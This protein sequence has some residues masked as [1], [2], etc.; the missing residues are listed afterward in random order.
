MKQRAAKILALLLALLMMLS[1]LAGCASVGP[2]GPQGATGQDGA[3]GETGMSAYE[4]AVERGYTGTVEEWIAS[5]SGAD[6]KSAYQLAVEKGYTGT[7]D[8]WLSSL[9][10]ENGRSAY[11]IAVQNGFVGSESAWLASLVGAQGPKGDKGDK[12][13]TGEQGAPGAAGIGVSDA[14]INNAYHLILVMTDGSEID[15]GYVGV[16][17]GPTGTSRAQWVA[18]L[19]DEAAYELVELPTTPTFTDISGHEYE[20]QIETAAY[21]ALID[22]TA[23]TFMPDELITREFATASAIKAMGYIP[24]D[25]IECDDVADIAEPEY[26]QLALELELV[27]LKDGSFCPVDVLMASEEA[28]IIEVL[29]ETLNSIS[30]PTGEEEGFVYNEGVVSLSSPAPTP[31]LNDLSDGVPEEPNSLV[32]YAEDGRL[33]LPLMPATQNLQPDQIITIDDQYAFKVVNATVE[34][35]FVLVEFVDPEIFEVLER[36]DIAGTANADITGFEPADGVVVINT[37]VQD[38]ASGGGE[39]GIPENPLNL[40]LEISLPRDFKLKVKINWSVVSAEYKYDIRFGFFSETLSNC[41][42]IHFFI[43]IKENRICSYFF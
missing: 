12:G 41:I 14:Y 19:V 27:A 1:S 7:V 4:M 24:G 39:I 37:P 22:T 35:E 9:V 23:A 6:G 28:K 11:E 30:A 18:L 13:D 40:E 10:G 21:Y 26:A 16:S 20:Q 2:A 38:L 31:S 32:Q 17:S 8:D 36:I 5:L 42:R 3:S 34:G 29:T 25:D 15:A 43:F 33:K